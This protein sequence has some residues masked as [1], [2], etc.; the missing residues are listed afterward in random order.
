MAESDSSRVFPLSIFDQHVASHSV[1]DA[2]LCSDH[3]RGHAD[4]LA[5][6][7]GIASDAEIDSVFRVEDSGLDSPS[8]S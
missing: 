3:R 2:A 8:T 6:S 1:T 7:S 4:T 5:C